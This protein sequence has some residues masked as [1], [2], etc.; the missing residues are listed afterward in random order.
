MGG[1][2]ADPVLTGYGQGSARRAERLERW[3]RWQVHARHG[4][5]GVIVQNTA[6][7]RGRG[8]RRTQSEPRGAPLDDRRRAAASPRRRRR[9][10]SSNLAYDDFL[11]FGAGI[12]DWGGVSP[13]TI[14]HVNGKTWLTSSNRSGDQVEVGRPRSTPADLPRL[15]RPALGRRAECCRTW[16]A[17]PTRRGSRA[18]TRGIRGRPDLPRSWSSTT[19]S[20]STRRPSWARP[21]SSGSSAPAGRSDNEFAAADRLRR[22]VCGDEVSYVVTR[23]IQSTN[24]CYFRCG[25]CAF[26]KRKLAANLRGAPYL[27]PH[28]EIVRRALEAG[29]GA[30]RIC[31]RAESIRASRAS[32]TRR[33]WLR[34]GLSYPSCTFTRSR[35][36]RSGRAR[37]RRDLGTFPGAAALGGRGSLPGRRPRS[38]MTRCAPSSA[39]TRSRRSNGWRCTTPRIGSACART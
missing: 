28:E 12:D 1:R 11:A 30:R 35:R 24:V 32:T 31:L 13:V 25:F 4:A 2:T 15:C 23:N 37:R 16:L 7:S 19:C 29:S 3:G 38:S 22:E 20:R 33:S 39:P 21:S 14:D 10:G 9:P 5:P 6:P 17:P 18:R 36:S 26:S 8:W 27:V 34:S